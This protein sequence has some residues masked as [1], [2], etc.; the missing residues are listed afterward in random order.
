[1]TEELNKLE[2]S[3]IVV[4][5]IRRMMRNFEPHERTSS[6]ETLLKRTGVFLRRRE[7][8]NRK[9]FIIATEFER[10]LWNNTTNDYDKE[11][12]IFAIDFSCKLYNYFEVHLSKYTDIS[13]A[14]MDKVAIQHNP[15]E[16]S[17]NESFN[18]EESDDDLLNTYIKLFEPFSNVSLK[19]SLFAGKKLTL[20][21]NL[22]LENKIIKD[23]F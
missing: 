21:N 15:T 6:I 16:V 4:H 5:T 2:I 9:N 8:T 1:M 17:I 19:K 3:I 23:G 11:T 22:I 7:K 14:L 13:V 12:K 10:R 20:K 18:I